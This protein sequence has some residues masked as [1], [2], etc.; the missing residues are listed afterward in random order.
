MFD[1]VHE[2]R[3]RQCKQTE[4]I[5]PEP[6][7]LVP[8]QNH[9]I[10]EL[11]GGNHHVVGVLATVVRHFLVAVQ[12][13]SHKFRQLRQHRLVELLRPFGAFL[14]PA[15]FQ[16]A[17]ANGRNGIV[18][19]GGGRGKDRDAPNREE[20]RDALLERFRIDAGRHVRANVLPFGKCHRQC[21][22][23]QRGGLQGI[24]TEIFAT[25]P[26]TVGLGD[27]D[28]GSRPAG[29]HDSVTERRK[30]Q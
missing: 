15:V 13:A 3:K 6:K 4:R 17:L 24:F 11:V 29:G 18:F 21:H 14:A 27:A 20:R 16:D 28:R 19:E 30:Q 1:I 7:R 2:R 25:H 26:D 22:G 10:Q 5:G 12:H 9:Q 8:R 23:C